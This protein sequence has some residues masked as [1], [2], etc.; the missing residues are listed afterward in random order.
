M[1]KIYKTGAH[2]RSITNQ[3]S[4]FICEADSPLQFTKE[5]ALKHD[6]IRLNMKLDQTYS[7]S[8]L[9]KKS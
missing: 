1:D 4:Y 9:Y 2:E 3:V 5:S 7:I 8:I 6:Q